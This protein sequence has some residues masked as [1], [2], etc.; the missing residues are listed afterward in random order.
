MSDIRTHIAA[1]LG[2]FLRCDSKGNRLSGR[3]WI[4]LPNMADTVISELGLHPVETLDRRYM[5]WAT[6]WE[7][8]PDWNGGK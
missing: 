7:N 4:N 3:E 5:R 6:K 8:N 1:A 2:E